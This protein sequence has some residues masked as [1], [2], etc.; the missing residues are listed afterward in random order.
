M[1]DGGTQQAGSIG[2]ARRHHGG[3]IPAFLGAN[4]KAAVAQRFEECREF[5]RDEARKLLELFMVGRGTAATQATFPSKRF[6]TSRV[7]RDLSSWVF[8]RHIRV[9]CTISGPS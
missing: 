4:G 3:R 6:V 7:P 2:K 1:F 9:S 8:S 5:G